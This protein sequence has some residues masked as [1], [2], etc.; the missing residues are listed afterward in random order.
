MP[1]V[2]HSRREKRWGWDICWQFA[3]FSWQY[4]IWWRG[5]LL[6]WPSRGKMALLL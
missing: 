6:D 4:P 5:L 1:K 2:S 3:W